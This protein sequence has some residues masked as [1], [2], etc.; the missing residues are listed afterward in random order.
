M[1]EARNIQDES[2]T[3]CSARK[4]KK[5]TKSKIPIALDSNRLEVESGLYNNLAV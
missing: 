2:G 4:F 5:S 3:S 1:T